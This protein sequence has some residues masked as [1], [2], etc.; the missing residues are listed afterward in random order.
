[1]PGGHTSVAYNGED[2]VAIQQKGQGY[3]KILGYDRKSGWLNYL[4]QEQITD[5]LPGT[6]SRQEFT[7]SKAGD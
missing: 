7:V 5:P 2:G 1:M 6:V 4:Y 3:L